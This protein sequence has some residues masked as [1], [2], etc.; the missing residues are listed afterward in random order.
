MLHLTPH[1]SS[2][3]RVEHSVL[4]ISQLQIITSAVQNCGEE[5][6][7]ARTGDTNVQSIIA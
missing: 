1:S 5:F 7:S 3:I 6:Q 4:E 2:F